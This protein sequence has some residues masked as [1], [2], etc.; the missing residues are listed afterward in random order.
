MSSNSCNSCRNASIKGLRLNERKPD[1]QRQ[2]DEQTKLMN[3]VAKE[4][5]QNPTLMQWLEQG[6]IGPATKD[7]QGRNIIQHIIYNGTTPD[8]LKSFLQQLKQQFPNQEVA[9]EEIAKVLNTPD[10]S[11]KNTAKESV[12]DTA[13]IGAVG[14]LGE[15]RD[16]EPIELVDILFENGARPSLEERKRSL[17]YCVKL[18]SVE[19]SE[20][21]SGIAL[22]KHLVH[23]FQELDT[24]LDQATARAVASAAARTGNDD[25]M[26]YILEHPDMFSVDAASKD[27]KGNTLLHSAASGDRDNAHIVDLLL[28]K[29]NSPAGY[30]NQINEKGESPLHVAVRHASLGSVR[31]LIKAGA[32]IHLK[33]QDGKTPLDI[34]NDLIVQQPANKCFVAIRKKLQE[35]ATSSVPID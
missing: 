21:H 23:K 13:F 20:T 3:T 9:N 12:K 35:A 17:L 22:F 14:T 7:K 32:N 26:Q 19:T 1:D 18:S 5:V 10:N 11:R 29:F 4:K 8:E 34:V 15:K 6:K 25:L 16:K 27:K 31:A 30:I 33:N 24:P 2:L 28:T